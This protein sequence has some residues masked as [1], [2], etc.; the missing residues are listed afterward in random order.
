LTSA[1]TPLGILGWSADGKALFVR[2]GTDVP[3]RIDRVEVAT[4]RR[5]F[6]AELGPADRTGLFAF[7][8]ATVS[9][10]G[11]QYAY[12]YRSRLSTLFV[13]SR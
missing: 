8:P 13:V 7:D 10:D 12:R 1:D 11:A 4:G 2:S 9:R 5:T 6:L 3:A